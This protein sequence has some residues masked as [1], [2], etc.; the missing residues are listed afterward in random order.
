MGAVPELRHLRVF[1]AVA[2]E[3]NFTRA[4]ERLHLAQQA[5]SKSVAQLERELGVRLL[6]RSTREVTLTAAGA[7]LLEEAPGLLRGAER[8]FAH[9]RA[10]G[11]G[12]E[13]R[14]RLG[15]SPAI[16]PEEVELLSRAAHADAP[17]LTIA[18]TPMWPA[19]VASALRARTID[20]AALRVP[21]PGRVEQL[22]PV[23][24]LPV[25][26]ALPVD[27]LLAV[28]DTLAWNDLDGERLVVW[29]PPGTPYTDLLLDMAQRHGAHLTPIVSKI[30]GDRGLP[31]VTT[32]SAIAL[33][34]AIRHPPRGVKIVV[35]EGTATLPL[36]VAW[37]PTYAGTAVAR[38]IARAASARGG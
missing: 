5:V 19:D 4:A 18:V 33:V 38:L 15:V 28:R 26:A 22:T 37:S 6:N 34:P 24:E 11:Q 12:E 32:G 9:A 16:G 31:D 2:E 13:G 17:E 14:L 36:L 35:L 30:V 7:A 3:R 1:V 25:A 29:N 23:A 20:L 8:A 21:P 27:H 10:I